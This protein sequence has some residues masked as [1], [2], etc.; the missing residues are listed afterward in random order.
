MGQLIAARAVQGM[1]GAGMVCLVSILI[2]GT[3]HT[4]CQLQEINGLIRFRHCTYERSGFVQ[5]LHQC[6]ADSG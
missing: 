3:N 5:E 6:R 2:T 1:G 4:F